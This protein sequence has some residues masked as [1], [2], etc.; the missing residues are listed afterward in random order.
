MSSDERLR[1]TQ[2]NRPPRVQL[3]R[4][5]GIEVEIPAP[6][7]IPEIPEQNLLITI[8]PVLGISVMAVLYVLRSATSG[9]SLR[10]AMP[11]SQGLLQ[12]VGKGQSRRPPILRTTGRM[13]VA[14]DRWRLERP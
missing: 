13:E 10:Q 1:T 5:D 4:L 7:P 11:T 9:G 2:F 3:P 12:E 6:P 14:R 8:L